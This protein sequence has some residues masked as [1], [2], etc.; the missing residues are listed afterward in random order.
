MS[1]SG[2]LRNRAIK[3]NMRSPLA[4]VIAPI[5]AGQVRSYIN[6]HP[7]HFVVQRGRTHEQIA[8]SISKRIIN[9]LLCACT[10]ARL[11]AALV[12]N[13]GVVEEASAGCV[14]SARASGEMRLVVSPES[15][16]PPENKER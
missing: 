2:V 14:T 11:T 7:D 13:V 10:C 5:V 16:P 3:A 9:D 4:R 6:D 12:A 15:P 8:V 1:A